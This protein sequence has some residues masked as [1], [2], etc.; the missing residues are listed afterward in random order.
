MT[1]FTKEQQAYLEANVEMF[2]D[3][4]RIASIDGRIQEDVRGSIFGDVLGH[5]GGTIYG[6]VGGRVRGTING[7]KWKYVDKENE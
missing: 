3:Y 7:R 6:N 4:L 1:K 2:D 5:V